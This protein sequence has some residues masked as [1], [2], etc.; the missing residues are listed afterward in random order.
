MNATK[1]NIKAV[2]NI[3]LTEVNLIGE[4]AAGKIVPFVPRNLLKKR[5]NVPLPAHVRPE[6]VEALEIKGD[7]LAG[8]GIYDG[9]YLI[10][11]TVFERFEVTPDRICIVRILTTDELIARRVRYHADRLVTL[12][13]ANPNYPDT[14]YF[15]DEIQV[16]GLG[17]MCAFD[18]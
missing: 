15:E 5:L 2:S 17:I 14:H 8:I 3:I 4:V 6:T 18:L 12:R 11:R 7:S 13:P 10:F 1:S 16:I 9:M